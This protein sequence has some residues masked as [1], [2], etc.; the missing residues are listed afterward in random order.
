MFDYKR[1]RWFKA[2]WRI[3]LLSPYVSLVRQHPTLF[4]A[5]LRQ[6]DH[7]SKKHTDRAEIRLSLHICPDLT[8]LWLQREWDG[9]AFQQQSVYDSLNS[10][11]QGFNKLQGSVRALKSKQAPVQLNNGE[12]RCTMT[13]LWSLSNTSLSRGTP[14]NDTL[15]GR[16]FDVCF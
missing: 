13:W 5:G 3:V 10:F 7:T 11:F 2:S 6:W 14:H 9:D 8:W 16:W 4:C 1:T 12:T 15:C